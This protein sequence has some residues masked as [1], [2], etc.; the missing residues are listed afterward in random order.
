MKLDVHQEIRGAISADPT[1]GG[2]TLISLTA[3]HT[4]YTHDS[5]MARF[6]QAVI[7]I[8]IALYCERSVGHH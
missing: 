7:E 1:H 5:N 8:Q 3:A 6:W 2:T 4:L